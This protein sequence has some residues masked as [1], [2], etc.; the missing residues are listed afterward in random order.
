[1]NR[2]DR[3]ES[4]R[5]L[6]ASAVALVGVAAAPIRSRAAT[7]DQISHTAESIHQEPVFTANRKRVYEA[8]TKQYE[9]AKVEEAKEIPS[10]RTLDPPRQIDELSK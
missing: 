4:R 1:M 5:Q 8:L 10:V 2:Q 9:L 7:G 6:L 3:G